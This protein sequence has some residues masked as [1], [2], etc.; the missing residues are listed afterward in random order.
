M[1]KIFS[2][3]LL[4]ALSIV[5]VKT[6]YVYLESLPERSLTLEVFSYLL[7]WTLPN[8]TGL[9]FFIHIYLYVEQKIKAVKNNLNKSYQ[10]LKSAEEWVHLSYVPLFI[11]FVYFLVKEVQKE[12][13]SPEKLFYLFIAAGVITCSIIAFHFMKEKAINKIDKKRREAILIN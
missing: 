12:N 10:L 11:T 6:S 3:G 7:N 8:L 13:Y 2:Q 4:F 9:L 5:F 1:K